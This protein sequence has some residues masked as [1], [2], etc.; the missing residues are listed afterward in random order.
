MRTN[1]I[2]YGIVTES[3]QIN[4]PIPVACYRHLECPNCGQR[5][6]D[7]NIEDTYQVWDME[8]QEFHDRWPKQI[9]KC[10]RCKAQIGI[11][12]I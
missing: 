10:P 8:D 6:I 7:V 1:C 9:G 5:L 11:T 4:R 2:E 12:E 3:I